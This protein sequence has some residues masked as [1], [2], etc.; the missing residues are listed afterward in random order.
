M[1]VPSRRGH[2][3]F[4]V[5]HV[6]KPHFQHVKIIECSLVRVFNHFSSFVDNVHYATAGTVAVPILH[7]QLCMKANADRRR[8]YAISVR[9]CAFRLVHI[10]IVI[11]ARDDLLAGDFA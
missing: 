4:V 1:Q 2:S 3:L 9:A 6:P 7:A 8:A 5:C 10:E 11:D